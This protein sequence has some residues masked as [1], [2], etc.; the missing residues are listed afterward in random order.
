MAIRTKELGHAVVPDATWVLLYTVPAGFTAIVKDIAVSS[1]AAATVHLRVT[2][3][4]NS[5]KVASGVVAANQTAAQSRFLVLEEGDA[6]EASRASGTASTD[7]WV[8]GAQ[9]EGVAA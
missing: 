7:V 5:W 2:R 3:A 8:S 6:L 4:G 1:T 9:L